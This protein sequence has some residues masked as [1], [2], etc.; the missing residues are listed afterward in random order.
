MTPFH[1]AAAIN[2]NVKYLKELLSAKSEDRLPDSMKRQP[3]HYAAACTGPDPLKV[4]LLHFSLAV[5]TCNH[6]PRLNDN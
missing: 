1:C 5:H 3:I 2:P 6:Q 4:N